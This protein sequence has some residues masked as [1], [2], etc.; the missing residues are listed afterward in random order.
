M[1]FIIGLSICSFLF[2]LSTACSSN[3]NLPVSPEGSSAVPST[4][5]FDFFAQT[6]EN[7]GMLFNGT[8]EIVPKDNI[9]YVYERTESA[10]YDITGFL[11]SGCPGGCFRYTIVTWVDDVLTIDLEIEN[12]TA[13]QVYDLRM[14]F[15]N[16]HGKKL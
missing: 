13:L 6:S 1:R 8:M 3:S 5:E 4:S 10:N 12:P 9:I 7:Y 11:A 15:T 14:V 16:L 2:L